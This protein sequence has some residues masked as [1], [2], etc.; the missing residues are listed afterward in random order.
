LAWLTTK[1]LF[2]DRYKK[3]IYLKVKEL[4]VEQVSRTEQISSTRVQKI[5]DDFAR[6]EIKNQ[7]WGMPKRLSLDE[8]SKKKG[9]GKFATI[10]TD[11]DR[12]S[13][14][15]VIDSHKSND[16]IKTLKRLPQNMR[17]QVEAWR[18][19]RDAKFVWTCGVVFQK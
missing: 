8:F 12:S 11:L 10:L 1:Q 2:T 13:L 19:T 18:V 5:F 9:H 17:E 16:I 14:L 4:T 15:E 7:D 3:Y 6:V